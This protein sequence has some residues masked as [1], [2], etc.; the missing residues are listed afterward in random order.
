MGESGTVLVQPVRSTSLKFQTGL[1]VTESRAGRAKSPT[2]TSG[3]LLGTGGSLGRSPDLLHS[4]E[5]F[6]LAPNGERRGLD[7]I[8]SSI[9]YTVLGSKRQAPKADE[10]LSRRQNSRVSRHGPTWV[11]EEAP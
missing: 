5:I 4:E 6:A 3:S 11:P 9:L 10:V 2:T 8:E 7:R 1:G